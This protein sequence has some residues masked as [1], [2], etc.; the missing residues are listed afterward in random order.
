MID[1]FLFPGGVTIV[2]LSRRVARH[3][4]ILVVFTESFFFNGIIR[5]SLISG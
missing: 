5:I 2:A 4:F 3:L 1:M